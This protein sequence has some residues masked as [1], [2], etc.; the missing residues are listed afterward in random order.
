MTEIRQG[1]LTTTRR[2]MLLGS[3]ALGAGAFLTAC[4]P[5][6]PASTRTSSASSEE[7]TP[8]RSGL[9]KA[10]EVPV[11]GGTILDDQDTVI[12]QPQPGQFKAF[13]ATCTHLGC[14]VDTV[15]DGTIRCPCHSSR[16]NIADGSV[17]HGPTT[18]PL[19]AKTV[20]L[21]GDILTIS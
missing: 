4:G 12:T 17:A 11:G 14:R 19:P 20:T 8:T 10:S 13:S 7:S 3:G 16:Y 21:N 5:H 9:L 18:K 1:H 15:Q 2:G 6:Q